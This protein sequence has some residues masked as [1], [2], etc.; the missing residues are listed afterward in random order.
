MGSGRTAS[1]GGP[2]P[3]PTPAPRNPMRIAPDL[4][5]RA[6]DVD[7]L[8]LDVD[9]VL[10]DGGL[11]YGDSGEAFKRFDVKDGH[12][13]VLARLVGLRAAV[14]TARRSK[15]VRVRFE[16]LGLAPISQGKKDKGAG[17]EALLEEAGVPASRAGYVGDDLNDLA[18]MRRVRLAACPS[19]A[20]AEARASAHY[21]AAAPGG[22]GAVREVVELLLRAQGRWD[23]VMKLML[24]GTTGPGGA[25]PP[26]RKGLKPAARRG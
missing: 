6:R 20:C 23:A 10:T 15:L 4:L 18:P 8:I 26:S 1:L 16:E 7:L 21:V 14:L 11:Y 2:I 24:E 19:D 3:S 17:L 22:H 5:R 12:G 13:L 25:A 9:G